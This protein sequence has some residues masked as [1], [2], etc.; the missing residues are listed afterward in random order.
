MLPRLERARYLHQ[1]PRLRYRL[2]PT[3]RRFKD[4]PKMTP[5]EWPSDGGSKGAA[6]RAL[7]TQ[8]WLPALIC[9]LAM[10]SLNDAKAAIGVRNA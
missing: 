2:S 5:P 1:A 4:A 7:S 10:P 3:H 9:P 8:G 6:G